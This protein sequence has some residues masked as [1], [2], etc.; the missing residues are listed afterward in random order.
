MRKHGKPDKIN[1]NKSGANKGALD[2]INQNYPEDQQI[3][4]IQNKYLNYMVEQDHR[5]IKKR[6]R[7]TLGL[8]SFYSASQTIKGIEIL[9][10]NKKGQ[11]K[12]DNNS[13]TTL[14]Q[15]FSLVA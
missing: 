13:K 10:M 12:N 2:A 5:F 8:K 1:V 4:I 11:L 9:H 15:F 3:E 7:I 14:E 6:T